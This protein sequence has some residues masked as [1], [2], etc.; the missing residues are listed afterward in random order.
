MTIATGAMCRRTTSRSRM[1]VWAY[2]AAYEWLDAAFEDRSA[3]MVFIAVDPR[4]EP[5]HGDP[6]FDA[7]LA[8]C[9]LGF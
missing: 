7:L 3:W 9:G 6:K 1:S 8:K 5:L 4:L 2:E